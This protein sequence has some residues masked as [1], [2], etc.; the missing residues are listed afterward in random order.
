M[1][2]SHN[3]ESADFLLVCILRLRETFSKSPPLI[4]V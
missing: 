4:T 1:I 2:V 3:L